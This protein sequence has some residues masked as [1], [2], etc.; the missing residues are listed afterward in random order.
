MPVDY[1]KSISI[2]GTKFSVMVLLPDEDL[3]SFRNNGQ[4]MVYNVLGRKY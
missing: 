4:E 2:D 1:R 3:N